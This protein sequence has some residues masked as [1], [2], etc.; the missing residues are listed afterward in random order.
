MV[1]PEIEVLNKIKSFAEK[2][3][4]ANISIQELYLFGSFASGK[5]DTNSDIDLA[6]LSNDFQGISFLDYDKLI[7]ALYES[8]K[9]IEP[10]TFKT[11]DAYSDP[12]F[13]S[14]IK[15]KGIRII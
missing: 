11:D 3:S 5:N 9:R 6:L 7:R 15:N 13:I 14:E 2:V 1:E 8:D 4:K 12:F 10:H